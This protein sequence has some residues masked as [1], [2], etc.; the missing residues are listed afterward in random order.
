MKLDQK[1]PVSVFANSQPPSKIGIKPG[2]TVTV[3]F[4]LQSLLVYSANDMA[5]VLAE[6]VAGTSY[7]FVR[8]MNRTAAVMGLTGTHFANPNGLF[9]PRQVTTARDL[10]I[11]A[12]TILR[13]VSRICALFLAAA[14]RRRQAQAAQPQSSDPADAGIGRHEDRFHLQFRLQSR[15]LRNPRR[16][17]ADRR[18]AGCRFGEEPA[19]IWPR[20][21]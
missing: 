20:C 16:P 14:C 4:A 11:L 15:R 10:G 9:D 21:C 18:R 5:V 19:P 17:A 1:I 2:G 7:Q 13:R 8:E 12:A 6:A 3:D